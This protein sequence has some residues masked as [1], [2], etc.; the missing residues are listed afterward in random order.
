MFLLIKIGFTNVTQI[1]PQ[2]LLEINPQTLLKINPQTLLK[3]DLQVLLKIGFTNCTKLKKLIAKTA[4][5][6]PL[7]PS[8]FKE[9]FI[10]YLN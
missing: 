6:K 9:N 1:D 10:I 8:K 3:I 2:V 7:K 5:L 4:R